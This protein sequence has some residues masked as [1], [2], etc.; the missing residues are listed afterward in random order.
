MWV[1]EVLILQQVSFERAEITLLSLAGTLP[2]KRGASGSNGLVGP[3]YVRNPFPVGNPNVR[4]AEDAFQ[5]LRE[6]LEVESEHFLFGDARGPRCVS[7]I[8]HQLTPIRN[9]AR[10]EPCDED[11][12]NDVLLRPETKHFCHASPHKEPRT[13]IDPWFY[14]TKYGSKVNPPFYWL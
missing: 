12:V 8:L 10:D 14:Y 9:S 1:G 11:L 2:Q 3:P 13:I 6:H 4:E 5:D 7:E